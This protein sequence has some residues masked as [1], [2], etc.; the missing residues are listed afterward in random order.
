MCAMQSE[1]LQWRTMFIFTASIHMLS[2]LFF[3]LLGANCRRHPLS[4][5]APHLDPLV[6]SQSAAPPTATP[7]DL[8]HDASSSASGAPPSGD[9][10]SRSAA[11]SDTE[12]GS[13]NEYIEPMTDSAK[14]NNL[15]STSLNTDGVLDLEQMTESIL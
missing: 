6:D 13:V 9:G 10:D 3:V 8:D 7:Q 12:Y 15:I 11:D 14:V 5:A 1:L 2:S 4:S